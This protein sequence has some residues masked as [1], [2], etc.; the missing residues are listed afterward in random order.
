MFSTSLSFEGLSPANA[1]GNSLGRGLVN[2]TQKLEQLAVS[3]GPPD[4]RMVHTDVLII[5]CDEAKTTMARA[6]RILRIH[7]P[8]ID[9]NGRHKPTYLP[10][11]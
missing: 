6:H 7:G 1:L 2:L 5:V 4:L 10:T 9:K 8:P 11:H 3:W